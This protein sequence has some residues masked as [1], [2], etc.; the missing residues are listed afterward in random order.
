MNRYR[1]ILGDQVKFDESLSN[2]YLVKV[3]A[4]KKQ[5]IQLTY[6]THQVLDLCNGSRTGKEILNDM[7]KAYPLADWEILESVILTVLHQYTVVKF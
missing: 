6:L 5:E 4:A 1:S 7:K 2:S 3:A